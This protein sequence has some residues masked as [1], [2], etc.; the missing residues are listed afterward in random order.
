MKT[1]VTG[2]AAGLI[3]HRWAVVVASVFLTALAA[4]G[5]SDLEYH[6]DY[7]IWFSPD[8]SRLKLFKQIEDNYTKSDNIYIALEPADGDVFSVEST[9]ILIEL[10]AEA[11]KTPHAIRVDGLSNFQ[12]SSSFGDDLY[13][14]PLIAAD[15]AQDSLKLSLAKSRA[16]AEPALLNRLIRKSADL[17]GINITLQSP[18]NNTDALSESMNYV[19]NLRDQMCAK[20]PGS[21]IY[22]SG[23]AA[24]NNAFTEAGQNDIRNLLPMMYLAITVILLWT[25]RTVI[26]SLLTLLV[27]ALSVIASMGSAGWFGLELTP[28]L[29]LA[30]NIVMTLAVANCV[31][32]ITGVQNQRQS[33]ADNSSSISESLRQNILPMTLTSLTT[34]LGFISLNWIPVPP[35][36]DLGNVTAFGV[37][38]ALLL[39]ITTLPALMTLLPVN[40][41]KKRTFH[42]KRWSHWTSW[43]SRR[44]SIA[45]WGALSISI[46][47]S[48]LI[49]LNELND[50]FTEYFSESTEFRQDTDYIAKRLTSPYQIEYTLKSDQNNG[51]MNPEYMNTIDQFSRWF[52]SQPDVV[53]VSNVSETIKRINMNLHGDD[54]SHYRIP[55]N[56]ALISQC[57]LLLEMSLPPG[58]DLNNQINV[59][60]SATRFVVTLKGDISTRSLRVLSESGTQW[61]REH[62]HPHMVTAGSGPSVMF[63]YI[64]DMALT[65]MLTGTSLALILVSLVLALALKDFKVGMVCFIPN[66]IP[67]AIGFGVWGLLSGK[68]GIGL[69][70][71]MGM[72]LGIVVDDTIHFLTK[73][74]RAK[75][76]GVPS[77]EE[78]IRVTF[79]NVG[80]A[81]LITTLTLVAG[82][83][84][85]A[86]ST[87]R[88]NADMAALT[89]ITIAVALIADFVLLPALL[90]HVDRSPKEQPA[91]FQITLTDRFR[92]KLRKAVL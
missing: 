55:D 50:R 52:L 58:L 59:D 5:L 47:L 57:L 86:L 62:S 77:V 54:S 25:L 3:N 22:I 46:L 30:P 84:I 67:M 7:R 70:P 66:L 90:L 27:T 65:N 13:V 80:S 64:S 75:R 73:Y 17:S 41:P 44:R 29:I 48:S 21:K 49:P 61:L 53:Q 56:S 12:Y 88:L 92:R 51:V 19:R 4:S 28:M 91:S 82:F 2:F 37:I 63:S 87:F 74:L 78:S 16:F 18:D 35:I 11:W 34:A 31:H 24:I 32:F 23:I 71:V 38:A 1:N 10:T 15:I 83:S 8:N 39:S 9:Q 60:K 36:N 72:T 45:L 85:L 89:A 68:I 33:G 43:L 79:D 42:E 6:S 20:H 69:A 81:M 40:T 76:S 26:G 14:R